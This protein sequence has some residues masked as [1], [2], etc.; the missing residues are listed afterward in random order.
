MNTVIL[1]LEHDDRSLSQVQI[2]ALGPETIIG[3]VADAVHGNYTPDG[4][5][6][7]RIEVGDIQ[8]PFSLAERRVD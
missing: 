4:A 5:R 6:L 8:S 2:D 1:T 3:M 7:K